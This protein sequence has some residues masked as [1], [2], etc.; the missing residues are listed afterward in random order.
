MVS[1]HEIYS[2]L[3]ELGLDRTRPAIAHVALTAFGD[4]R[5]GVETLLGAVLASVKGLLMPTFTY[6]TM[7]IPENGPE[8]NGSIYGSGKELNRMAEF[9]T[10]DMPADKLMGETAEALRRSSGAKRSTHPILSFVGANLN[11][12]L[13]T[14]TMMDP[15]APLG[16]LVEQN[17]WVLLAGVD[18][19]VNTSIHYVEKIM[20]RKQ[21]L[22]WALIPYRIV[23][24]PGFPGCSDGFDRAST[25]LDLI[26]N[27]ILIGKAVVQ[28][29]PLQL[30]VEVLSDLFQKD[31]LALLCERDDCERCGA[32][33]LSLV[34][35]K[36]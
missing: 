10:A 27:K 30:M 4:V 36:D 7:I 9:F 22:R 8:N 11:D 13:D 16:E 32:I 24:C 6:K 1:F 29:L 12:I 23:E 20:G 28:A 18:H 35:E 19:T 15:L 3:R 21:F 25:L 26:T 31:P 33:R 5:G 34:K 17:A 2:G 14:Q